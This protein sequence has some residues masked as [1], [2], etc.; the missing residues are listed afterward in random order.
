MNEKGMT[1]FADTMVFLVVMMM[2]ITVTA[3]TNQPNQGADIGP[4]DLLRDIGGIEVRLSDLT[5]IEDDTLVFLPD[6][7]ALSLVRGTDVDDYLES[8]L[9]SVFGK[10]RYYLEFQYGRMTGS[11]GT[12]FDYYRF[13]DSRT[14]PVSTGGTIDVTLS[15]L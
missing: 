4:D 15:T 7:M 14:I 13:Q 5:D 11:V 2:A 10:N 3:I 12:E 8:I 9:D 1:A 6:L